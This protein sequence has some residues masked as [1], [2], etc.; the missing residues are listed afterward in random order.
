MPN[1]FEY[2]RMMQERYRNPTL[3]DKTKHR[4]FLVWLDLTR[5]IRHPLYRLEM[6]IRNWFRRRRGQELYRL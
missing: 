4:A 5:P 2:D 3:A 1:I 6:R